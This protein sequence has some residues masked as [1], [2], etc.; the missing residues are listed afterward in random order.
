[1][2][3]IMR[4][5]HHK[6]KLKNAQRTG[7]IRKDLTEK[8]LIAF[9]AAALAYNVLEDQIDALL[10]I[11]TNVPDWLIKE[12]SSRIHGL[13]GKTAIIHKALENSDLN[14]SDRKIACDSVGA[15]SEFK[16][17]RDAIV[18]ARII[19]AA[20]GIGLSEKTRGEKSFEV[21]LTEEALIA[22]Y[23]HVTALGKVLSDLSQLLAGTNTLNSL[24]PSDPNKSRYEEQILDQRAQFRENHRLRRSLKQLPKFPP[25][26]EM[27]AAVNRWREAQAATQMGWFQQWPTPLPRRNNALLDTY[28]PAWVP[29]P[30]P[31]QKK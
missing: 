10:H 16:K 29:Q 14:L 9:A 1:M 12:V 8:Q 30:P 2:R 24:A 11:V 17:I 31:E 3:F 5:P 27:N 23:D 15:F 26:S 18:H 21:L 6:N 4:R 28:Y 13:D 19:D 25:E 20:I 7:D 22:F